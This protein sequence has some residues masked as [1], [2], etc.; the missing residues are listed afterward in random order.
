[1]I[2]LRAF[3]FVTLLSLAACGQ[4]GPVEV[5]PTATRD[6]LA[7][8]A[9]T[10]ISPGKPGNPLEII[11]VPPVPDAP[12]VA[13]AAQTLSGELASRTGLNVTVTTVPTQAEALALLCD[14]TD[15]DRFPAVWLSG[16]SAVL[17]EASG[18]G[19]RVLTAT[20]NGEI[21]FAGE[22]VAGTAGSLNSL[23]GRSLCEYESTGFD[24]FYNQTLPMLALQAAN[25]DPTQM[26]SVETVPR[27]FVVQ[28]LQDGTCFAVGGPAGMMAEEENL[29][30]VYTS[31]LIPIGALFVPPELLLADEEALIR[32]Y[33]EVGGWEDPGATAVDGATATPAP[34]VTPLPEGQE[35][36]P[37]E[38]FYLGGVNALR[39]SSQGVA[40]TWLVGGHEV[41]PAA[42]EDLDEMRAFMDQ[43]GFD[44]ESYT[45][46]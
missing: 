13:T 41:R 10:A 23:I 21:G 30:V 36:P 22:L 11:Y 26:Q 45:L 9:P 17:A 14:N 31:P 29:T 8:F 7:Y 3:I 4:R 43:A 39:L 5:I 15:G 25:L 38:P 24:A 2:R 20:F 33:L 6:P 28:S 1:M 37:P 27:E 42:P 40:L 18:C 46:R 32:A 34:T 12:E 16:P 19:E 35:I 44:P